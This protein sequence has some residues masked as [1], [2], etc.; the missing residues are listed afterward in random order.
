PWG[1]RLDPQIF[2]ARVDRA[3]ANVEAARAAV[4]NAQASVQKAQAGI[5]SAVANQSNSRAEVLKAQVAVQ[6]SQVKYERRQKLAAEGVISREDLDTAQ[7]TYNSARAALDAAK[8]QQQA[9]ADNVKA[10]QA[11]AEVSRTLLASAQAQVKQAQ[12]AL[13][14][15]DLDLEHTYIR[16]PVDGVVVARNVDVGQTVAASLQAPTLFQIA[17]DLTNMQVDTNV[18]EADVGRVRVGQPATF[19]VD[20]YPGREFHGQVRDIR[21]APINVQNVITY[22]VVIGVANPDLKLFPGMTA[23]VKILV[24]EHDNVLKVPNAALRFKPEGTEPRRVSAGETVWVLT[25]DNEPKAVPVSVGLNDG[26]STE[27]TKGD[28]HAG[29]KVIV[30]AFSKKD[31]GSASSFGSHGRRGPF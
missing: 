6:D 13:E 3:Q 31:S 19:T 14:Q 15:A 10:A 29:D 18:S 16:A 25:K 24:D 30:A 4:V 26:T 11:D 22:D 7:N 20:A 28:L 17:Q 21:K 5:A 8:A 2:Q 23:N 12:A 9:A 27:I 1:A